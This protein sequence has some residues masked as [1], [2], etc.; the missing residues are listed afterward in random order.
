MAANLRYRRCLQGRPALTVNLGEACRT[1][2]GACANFFLV[3]AFRHTENRA[4][5]Y[6]AFVEAGPSLRIRRL[7][8]RMDRLHAGSDRS[9]KKAL[10]I[11]PPTGASSFRT[12]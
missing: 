6:E 9:A 7:Q 4:C 5:R 12:Q 10:S 8:K 1:L 3:R 2:P 11:P